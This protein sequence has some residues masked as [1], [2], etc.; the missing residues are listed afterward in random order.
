[1]NQ[2]AFSVFT[3][4]GS[5][6]ADM[7]GVGDEANGRNVPIPDSLAHLG[8]WVRDVRRTPIFFRTSTGPLHAFEYANYQCKTGTSVIH[9]G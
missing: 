5:T 8:A 1:M 7:S 4:P 3:Q 6:A 9:N 2:S